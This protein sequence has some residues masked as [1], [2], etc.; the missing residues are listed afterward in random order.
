MNQISSDYSTM[1]NVPS[2][3]GRM[4]QWLHHHPKQPARPTERRPH[5]TSPK[6]PANHQIQQ[7]PLLHH[8]HTESGLRIITTHD[9]HLHA[10]SDDRPIGPGSSRN[11]HKP[12]SSHRST[13]LLGRIRHLPRQP[14]CHP[15]LYYHR[16]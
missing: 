7:P 12:S 10:S 4:G 15:R 3:C 8:S 5:D 16:R 6:H 2:N 9:Q 11:H 13:R 14:R 1:G